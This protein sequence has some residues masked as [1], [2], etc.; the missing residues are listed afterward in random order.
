MKTMKKLFALV[1]AMVMI[2]ALALPVMAAGETYTITVNPSDS[3]SAGKHEGHTYEAYQ[4]LSGTASVGA[5]SRTVLADIDWGKDN[6][7]V[8]FPVVA[9]LTAL[10]GN[11]AFGAAGANLFD[12]LTSDEAGAKKFAEKISMNSFTTAQK[13]ALAQTVSEV[14]RNYNKDKTE[15]TKFKPITSDNT[16]PYQLTVPAGYYMIKDQDGSLADKENVDYTDIIL[17]VSEAVAVHHKGSIPTVKKEVSE[18]N[19]EYDE[20]VA[21]AAGTEFYYKLIGTLP[22]DFANYDAY[23]YTFS[24]ELSVGI[25]YAGIERVFISRTTGEEELHEHSTT[26]PYGYEVITSGNTVKIK[27][28]DLKHGGSNPHALKSSDKIV[29]IYKAKLNANANI[30][31]AGNENKVKLEYSNNPNGEGIGSTSTDSTKTYTYGVRLEKYDGEKP[32]TKLKDVKFLL[33]REV[34]VSVVEGG[35]KISVI[36]KEYAEVV[37]N[38]IKDWHRQEYGV[39]AIPTG[40]TEM[41]TDANGIITIRGLDSSKDYYLQE[42]ATNAG[43]NKIEDPIKFNLTA[44]LDTTTE[45]ITSVTATVTSDACHVDTANP[46]WEESGV[47]M[48][49]NLKVPNYKGT[50]LPT[51]GGMGTTLFYVLGSILVIGAVVLLVTKKRMTY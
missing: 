12:D 24:D 26:N 17:Q 45:T 42:T 41:A 40:A 8:S 34:S 31:G 48:G 35:T 51:T 15:A 9:F 23:Q 4:I 2:M 21:V 43:F 50:V 1:L 20:Y 6:S 16:V 25:T 11:T 27:F 19:S 14:I 7:G 18:Y 37:D 33:Y 10:K 38:C 29:V 5:D 32:D 49:V 47:K 46:T 13:E 36:V 30:G 22:E 28:A 3:E 44:K 39:T